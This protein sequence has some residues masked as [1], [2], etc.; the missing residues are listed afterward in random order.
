MSGAQERAGDGAE[1]ESVVIDN[2][3][4]VHP[5]GLCRDFRLPLGSSAFRRCQPNECSLNDVIV[6][7]AV[8]G[9]RRSPELVGAHRGT[10][11]GTSRWVKCSQS[12]SPIPRL[13]V[14][15]ID[16]IDVALNGMEEV[17]GSI[18]IRSTNYFTRAG[19]AIPG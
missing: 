1:R 17:I 12:A 4:T 2:P 8:C 6:S 11:M 16:F 13:P 9:S 14:Y 19:L 10:V 5:F 3:L 15:P 7:P 18:P